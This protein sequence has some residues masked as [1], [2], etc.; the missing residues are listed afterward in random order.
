M[1]LFVILLQIYQVQLELFYYKFGAITTVNKRC[2]EQS[3]IMLKMYANTL[4]DI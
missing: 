4:L 1:C 3:R 2:L